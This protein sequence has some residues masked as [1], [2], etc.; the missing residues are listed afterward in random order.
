MSTLPEPGNPSASEEDLHR[1][2][3]MELLEEFRLRIL[4]SIIAFGI[5]VVFCWIFVR[6]SADLLARPYYKA[7]P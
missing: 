4:K 6:E 5:V 2:S 1:M 3:L 7:L